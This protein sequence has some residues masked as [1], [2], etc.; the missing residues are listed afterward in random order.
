[1]CFLL[2]NNSGKFYKQLIFIFFTV[3]IIVLIDGFFQYLFGVNLLGFKQEITHR[4]SGLFGNELILGSF[5]S[6]YLAFVI[7][8]LLIKE[9]YK[10]LTEKL[11]LSDTDSNY[12]VYKNKKKEEKIKF[13]KKFLNKKKKKKED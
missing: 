2:L 5:I 6:K 10:P 8:L 1:M 7:L 4:V 12:V 9:K 13:F 11:G 3:F